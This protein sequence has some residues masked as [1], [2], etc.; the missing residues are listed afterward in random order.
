M[1]FKRKAFSVLQFVL[2]TII[3]DLIVIITAVNGWYEVLTL[4]WGK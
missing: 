4:P 1:M 3:I 2:L